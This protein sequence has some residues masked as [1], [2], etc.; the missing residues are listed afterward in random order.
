MVAVGSSGKLEC[1]SDTCQATER[2]MDGF[3]LQW[4]PTMGDDDD[5]GFCFALGTKGPCSSSE[6]YGFN[7]HSNEGQ[8]V[9]MKDPKT[10]YFSSPE[11][12]ALLDEI[13]NNP[14]SNFRTTLND[15]QL[16]P[17][18]SIIRT[19]ATRGRRQGFNT[20]GIFQQPSQIPT[21]LL[22]PCQTGGR[23]GNNFK[24]TN[25]LV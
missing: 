13:Y 16:L 3:L 23:F 22:N 11:E 5:N 2:F 21:S 20:V 24:C 12:N 19:R 7:I 9:D 4:V 17:L 1:V 15:T 10:P 18:E 6:L 25:P 8:C 14:S